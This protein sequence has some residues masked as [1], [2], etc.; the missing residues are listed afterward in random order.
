M[1]LRIAFQLANPMSPDR[2]KQH[3]PIGLWLFKSSYILFSLAFGAALLCLPWQSFWENNYLL[4]MYPELR[5]LIS[6]SYFK[7]AVLGLGIAD[8]L[9]GIREITRFRESAK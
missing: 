4:Y 6:N 3:L 1:A 8:I 2:G 5:P 9:I 7:G